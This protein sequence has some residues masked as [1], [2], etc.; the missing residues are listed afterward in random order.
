MALTE[1]KIGTALIIIS[2]DSP[3]VAI[4]NKVLSDFSKE[5]I[6]RQ[7]LSLKDRNYNIISIIFEGSIDRIN[8]LAGKIGRL[9]G[10]K[11]KLLIAKN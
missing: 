4:L 7:G 5:I 2:K 1:K 9:N 6:S 8:S 10:I 11:I 3:S